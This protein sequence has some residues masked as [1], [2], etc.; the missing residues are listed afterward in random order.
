MQVIFALFVFNRKVWCA[1]HLRFIIP[2]HI[3]FYHRLQQ[4]NSHVTYVIL[5]R[6]RM[7]HHTRHRHRRLIVFNF[8]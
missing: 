7:L 3:V 8:K 4:R 1:I 5:P 6:M 2:K